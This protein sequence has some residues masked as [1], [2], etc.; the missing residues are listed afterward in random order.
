[1]SN[2][3]L[4]EQRLT[5]IVS[6][7]VQVENDDNKSGDVHRIVNFQRTNEYDGSEWYRT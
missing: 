4:V 7:M 2:R 6:A 5:A 1:M 3:G